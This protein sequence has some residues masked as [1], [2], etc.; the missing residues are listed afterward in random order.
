M[1]IKKYLVHE[2]LFLLPHTLIAK[3][4]TISKHMKSPTP[5]KTKDDYRQKPPSLDSLKRQQ[6]SEKER[7][8]LLDQLAFEAQKL[9]LGY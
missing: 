4:Y 1:V 3:K 6:P 9:K 7:R 2:T 5:K 8:M